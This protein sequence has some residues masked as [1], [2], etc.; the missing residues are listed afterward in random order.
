[1]CL[2]Q[3]PQCSDAVEA[4]TRGPPSRVKHSTTEPLRFRLHVSDSSSISCSSSISIS[5][6]RSYGYS[7][8]KKG[9]Y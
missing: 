4:L 7:S 6:R 3:G 5:S 8:R 2:A 9:C 1:M